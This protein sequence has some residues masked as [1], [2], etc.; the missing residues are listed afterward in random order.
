MQANADDTALRRARPRAR[1]TQTRSS[2]LISLHSGNTTG[3]ILSSK[4]SGEPPLVLATS[5]FAAL[6]GAIASARFDVG[7]KAFF[8]MPVPCTIESVLRLVAPARELLRVP[9]VEK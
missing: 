5:V 2:L 3:R 7:E 1:P 9:Y 4:A 6:R 8:E